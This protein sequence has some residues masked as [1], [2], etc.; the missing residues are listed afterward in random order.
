MVSPSKLAAVR[1]IESQRID[2]SEAID[3]F[4]LDISCH[5]GITPWNL[6]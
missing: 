3:S 6:H 5:L 4:D 2:H 1:V